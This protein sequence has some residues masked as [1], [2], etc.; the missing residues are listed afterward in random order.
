[1]RNRAP[2]TILEVCSK[3]PGRKRIDNW[4]VTLTASKSAGP[5]PGT[6]I[7]TT[8]LRVPFVSVDGFRFTIGRNRT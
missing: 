5:S 4:M 2:S 1:M 3:V 8:R 6:H 7:N